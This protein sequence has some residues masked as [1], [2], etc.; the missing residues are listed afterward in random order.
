HEL[1]S[2]SLALLHDFS[3][4]GVAMVEYKLNADTGVPYLMEI[5]GRLW[6]SLQL[7]IDAGVDFPNLLVQSAL[8]M[9][10][11]PVTN[12]KSGVR[13]RWEWGEVDHLLAS[14]FHS[15]PAIAASRN[16]PRRGRVA[17][18]TEFFRGFG[19]ANRPE[20]FR[21]DDPRPFLRETADWFRRR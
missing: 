4:Q 2:R 20:V 17:A 11:T 18:L 7:A 3:W 10:L 14:L 16:R 9:N 21:R 8:G 15:S 19:E 13:L 5:N 1:L 6:G 12:Y